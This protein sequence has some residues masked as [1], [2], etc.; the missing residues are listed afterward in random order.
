MSIKPGSFW[1][2]N[3]FG[4]VINVDKL[5]VIV[6]N[7]N[8]LKWTVDREIFDKEFTV[9]DDVISEEP[10]SRSNLIKKILDFPR[11]AMTIQFRKKVDPEKVTNAALDA[12]SHTELKKAIKDTL[13][14]EVRVMKGRH[15]GSFDEHG[16]LRFTDMEKNGLRLIDPRTIEWA[17]IDGILYEVK[18]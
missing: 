10:I 16:R 11:I 14:G 9:A 2:R 1:S 8:G 3:S 12:N 4:K 13:A 17:I 7:E 18:S 6:Q 15:V 5:T